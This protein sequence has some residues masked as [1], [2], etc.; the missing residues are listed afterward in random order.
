VSAPPPP[1]YVIPARY[2]AWLAAPRARAALVWLVALGCAIGFG[3][4]AYTIFDVPTSAGPDRARPDGNNG[5]AQI[6]FGGQYL[7]GRMIVTGN[8]RRL[9]HRQVQWQVARDSFRV[10]DESRLQ[11]QEAGL[12]SKWRKLGRADEEWQHDYVNLMSWCMGCD[13]EPDA[14]QKRL[15]GATALLFAQPLPA[16]PLVAVAYERAAANAVT[17]EVVAKLNEPVIGGPLYPPVHALMYAPLAL[18]DRP[19]DAYRV[20]QLISIALIPLAALGVKVLTRGRVWWSVATVLIFVHP[21]TRGGLDLGQNPC[22]TLCIVVW[23]WV[24]ASRGRDG[25]GGAAWGLLAFKPVWAAALFLVPLLTGRW[26]FALAMVGTGAVL[27]AA[28]IPLVGI[29]NWFNW[30]QIGREASELY[31]H[32]ENWISLSRD[33]Q[34]IPRRAMFDFTK[35]DENR[36]KPIHDTLGWSLWAAVMVPTVLIYVL[37]ADRRRATGT[38]AAFLFLGAYLTCF[39]FMYY[40]ALISFVAVA[41][42]LAEP[43]RLFR[44]KAFAVNPE[45]V[46]LGA[47]ESRALAAPP[48]APRPFGARMVGYVNSFPLTVLVALFV[49]ENWIAGLE[50]EATVGMRILAQPGP[51]GRAPTAGPRVFGDTS[52]RY[53][54]DTFLLIALWGWCGYRLLR[55][56]ER[57]PPDPNA[58]TP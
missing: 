26:R 30:L 32:N 2:W 46:E 22:V 25:A 3:Y 13:H 58:L 20:F 50:I 52:V 14:E 51:D 7:M 16:N 1:P 57:P 48:P 49:M 9:Y 11:Q 47:P 8:G 15:G 40:D 55:G 36:N 23:G 29:E 6:D 10:S 33:L 45:P 4:R 17:P 56:D 34:G 31:K 38:G 27:G 43:R 44:A 19:Q 24:L 12:P 53:P 54:I 37:R 35:P 28:T 5:H 18:I 42:L 41:V 21:G 39:H